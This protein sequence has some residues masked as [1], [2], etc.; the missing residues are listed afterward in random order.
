MVHIS[1]TPLNYI[2]DDRMLLDFMSKIRNP[3]PNNLSL[4]NKSDCMIKLHM[5]T[6][7]Y[8]EI[9]KKYLLYLSK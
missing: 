2:Y 7:N 6:P 8:Q 4:F 9:K 5:Y 3:K 1:T